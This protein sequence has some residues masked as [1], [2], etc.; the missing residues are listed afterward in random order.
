MKL[1]DRPA[2]TEYLREHG[3]E[4]SPL[5]V[6][7]WHIRGQL[8]VRYIGNKAFSTRDDLDALLESGMPLSRVGRPPSGEAA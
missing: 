8:P 7:N 5:T 2:I 1:F 3:V 4:V 6:R